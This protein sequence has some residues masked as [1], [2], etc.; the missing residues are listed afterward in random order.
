MIDYKELIDELKFWKKNRV[1]LIDELI[2]ISKE[3]DNPNI[4]IELGEALINLKKYRE[5]HNCLVQIKKEETQNPEWNYLMGICQFEFYTEA[6]NID[7][8]RLSLKYLIT[9]SEMGNKKAKEYLDENLKDAVKLK[10][11][12]DAW[13]ANL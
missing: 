4:I 7:D 5:A 8:L 3:Q 13:P 2:R 11:G 10:L 6:D 12:E 1:H 9:A